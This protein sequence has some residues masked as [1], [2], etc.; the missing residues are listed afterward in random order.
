M[1]REIPLTKGYVALVDDEDYGWLSE[2]NWFAYPHGHTVYGRRTSYEGG[3][4]TVILHRVILG[5]DG[6]PLL[7]GD[8]INGNGLDNRRG[9][10]RL[11]TISQNNC[12]AIKKA[13]NYKG[14]TLTPDRK[15][16]RARITANGRLIHIGTFESEI[17]AA[18]AY[19]R[20]ARRYHGEFA[21]L[22]FSEGNNV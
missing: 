7:K 22:N 4:H 14:A 21:K 10:L 17:E 9:N 5:I 20:V 15:K 3:Q 6:D 19:D 16:W 11:A 18:R 2:W 12:N 13:G 1:T 8:H